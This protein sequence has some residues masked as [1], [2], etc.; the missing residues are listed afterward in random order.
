MKR[1]GIALLLTTA[2]LT[3]YIGG[4]PADAAHPLGDADKD[5]AVTSTDARLILQY[6]VGKI[7]ARN[8]DLDVADVDD[9]GG[10]TS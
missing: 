9:D 1:C 7:G 2:V 6:S 5:G 3:A 8:L 4:L 10:V